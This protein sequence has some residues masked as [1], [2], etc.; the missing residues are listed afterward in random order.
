MADLLA[1]D[2]L[3]RMR[4]RSRTSTM[5]H[6]VKALPRGLQEGDQADAWR[7][8]A[9]G[10][11]EAL[12]DLVAILTVDQGDNARGDLVGAI[13]EAL[14]QAMRS[15]LADDDGQRAS[16]ARMCRDAMEGKTR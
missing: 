11:A 1:A 2:E 6:L 12:G 16:L 15:S 4:R 7:E 5:A 14:G 8:R 13:D 3:A 10:A 9:L